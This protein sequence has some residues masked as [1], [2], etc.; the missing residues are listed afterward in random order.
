MKIKF[1]VTK[2]ELINKINSLNEED[3]VVLRLSSAL[4]K[5]NFD[6]ENH[7]I[8]DIENPNC[9]KQCK[10]REVFGSTVLLTYAGG[11]WEYPVSFIL[12]IDDKGKLKGFIPN[13]GNSYNKDTKQAFGNDVVADYEFFID[14]LK[15][16]EMSYRVYE[17]ALS[18]FKNWDND[19]SLPCSE[20]A[21]LEELTGDDLACIMSEDAMIDDFRIRITNEE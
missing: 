7:Y 1:G 19:Y 14:L 2:D 18:I 12:Y 13:A 15:A 4:T 17:D 5:V 8:S 9:T 11:D 3:L 21:D 10:F 20:W 6:W 16:N